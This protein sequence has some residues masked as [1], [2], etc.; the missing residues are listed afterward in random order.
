MNILYGEN[1][2]YYK[3]AASGSNDDEWEED[4][5]AGLRSRPPARGGGEK[6]DAWNPLSQE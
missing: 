6:E 2:L 5:E 1:Q 4:Q 3:S